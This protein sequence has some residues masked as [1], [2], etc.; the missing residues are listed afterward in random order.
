LTQSNS[1]KNT[2]SSDSTINKSKNHGNRGIELIFNGGKKRQPKPFRIVLDK[3]VCFF[4]RE[5][6][7]Y[8]EF[9]FRIRK[10]K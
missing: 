4:K 3:M 1:S 6:N 8:L 9:S 2:K 7:I 5:V 10:I